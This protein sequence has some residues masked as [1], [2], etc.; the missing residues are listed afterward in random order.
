MAKKSVIIEDLPVLDNDFFTENRF[1][2][3]YNMLL[4]F[5]I[6]TKNV[7]CDEIGNIDGLDFEIN[8]VLLKEVIYDAMIG[9]KT[10]VVSENNKVKAPNPFKIAAY[11]GYWFLRHKPLIFRVVRNFDVEKIVFPSNISADEQKYLIYKIKHL[12]E[13][14]VTNFLLRYIFKIDC[15]NRPTCGKLC[16]LKVKSKSKNQILYI[17]PLYQWLNLQKTTIGMLFF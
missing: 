11:L 13:V 1:K 8:E 12:N 5:A 2:E 4:C 3:W 14:A 7:L 9:L 15:K 10:I 17:N 16:Y 6:E